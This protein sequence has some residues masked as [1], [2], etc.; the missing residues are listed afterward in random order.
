MVDAGAI[1][2]AKAVVSLSTPLTIAAVGWILNRTIQKQ[3]ARVQRNSSWRI[4]WAEEFL[5]V[6]NKFNDAATNFL[7][8]FWSLQFVENTPGSEPIK[9]YTDMVRF[10][11][12]LLRFPDF[13]PSNGADLAKSAKALVQ[14]AS[15]WTHNKGGSIDRFREKQLTFNRNA[16]RVHAELLDLE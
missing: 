14:E 9:P 8:A 2:I 5:S 3:N 4:A 6:S 12:H 7:M 15:D 10:E 11:Y 1:E 13:A 16:R